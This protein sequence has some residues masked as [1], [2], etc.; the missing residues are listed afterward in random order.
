MAGEESKT[1]GISKVVTAMVSDT[2][3]SLD[4]AL[5]AVAT[6]ECGAVVSFS[7]VVRNHDDRRGVLRLNYSA[8][9]SAN[10][11]IEDIATEIAGKYAGVRLWA[12]HRIGELEVGDAALVAA[13]SAAHRG[14]AFDACR[15]LVESVKFRLPIWKE[16]VFEDGDVEWVGIGVTRQRER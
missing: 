6:D 10:R 11:I 12:A 15:D 9:P 8:H 5:S 3:I 16:Q 2:A 7:G 4:A 14:D 1:P 13:V